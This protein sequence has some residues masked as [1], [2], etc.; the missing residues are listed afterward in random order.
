[1]RTVLGSGRRCM[2]RSVGVDDVVVRAFLGELA[3]HADRDDR[4]G[5]PHAAVLGEFLARQDLA[6]RHAG[7]VGHEALDL[8]HAAFVEP[9]FEVAEGEVVLVHHGSPES[10]WRCA[11]SVAGRARSGRARWRQGAAR[12]EGRS[13]RW[14][15]R[16]VA[17]AV[18]AAGVA[19]GTQQAYRD[20]VARGLPLG[21]PLHAEVEAAARGRPRRP[22]PG[23]PARAPRRAGPAARRL[24]ALAV[25][26]VHLDCAAR[27]RMPASTPP[28]C[29][30][31]RVRRGRRLHLGRVG[32]RRRRGG[33]A[34]P[35]TSCTAWCS[36]AAERD[37]GL[38][39]AAADREQRDAA[40]ERRAG[41][42]AASSRRGRGRAAAWCRARPR[43]SGAGAR[44]TASRSAARRRPG[45]AARRSRSACGDRARSAAGSRPG[46]PRRCTCGRRCG[47]D[48]GRSCGCSG[49]APAT[50]RAVVAQGWLAAVGLHSMS[51]SR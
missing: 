27:A 26:R 4:L 25:H 38:L 29:D 40:L 34:G 42:A 8:G 51:L 50:E 39:E 5:Q 30:V 14:L 1:M 13:A 31:D 16:P 6:A 9:L 28:G 37:V 43:R 10:C 36:A 21:V 23:R 2:S 35:A 24:H 45:R 20:R 15:R 48:A 17:V 47:R 22:R 41:S 44:W 11:G 12:L 46:A 49:Q 32:V 18:G 7:E 3:G 19:E 33:R